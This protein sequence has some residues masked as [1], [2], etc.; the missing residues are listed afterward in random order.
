MPSDKDIFVEARA[1][2]SKA[3]PEPWVQTQAR[4]TTMGRQYIEIEHRNSNC[5]SDM[6]CQIDSAYLCAAE[7]NDTDKANAALIAR[8]PELLRA[9]ADEVE[10][11]RDLVVHMHV[12]SGY[13]DNG[14]MQMTTPQKALYDAIWQRSVEELDAEEENHH[15]NS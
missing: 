6:I 1:L 7:L 11:L 5:V 9:L 2:L 4:T 10:R 3:T 13:R 8:S 12:H 14:Y 15:A